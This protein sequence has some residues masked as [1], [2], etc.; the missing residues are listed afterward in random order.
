MGRPTQSQIEAKW[1]EYREVC[2]A[3]KI[4]MVPTERT[5]LT[6]VDHT[7]HCGTVW[8]VSISKLCAKPRCNK[9]A[10]KIVGEHNSR[11]KSG[12]PTLDK[13]AEKLFL[14]KLKAAG[15]NRVLVGNFLGSYVISKFKCTV[16]GTVSSTTG[17][18][19][20]K[21]GCRE[22]SGHATKTTQQHADE[23]AKAGIIPTGYI[24]AREQCWYECMA[25]RFQWESMPTNVLKKPRCPSCSPFNVY[26]VHT[27]VHGKSHFKLRSK[28]EL[29]V[30]K[31]LIKQFG[32]KAV[33]T[34]LT[35]GTPSIDLLKGKKHRPDFYIERDNLLVEVKGL[36]T[37]G[38]KYTSGVFGS[39]MFKLLKEKE[40]CAREQGFQYEVVIVDGWRNAYLELPDNWQYYTTASLRKHAK[41][42]SHYHPL[43]SLVL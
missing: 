34:D 11:L 38:L 17:S 14:A 39:G 20:I 6:K 19:A 22:C 29:E 4:K 35:H 31:I 13:G 18:N 41:E 9:C 30:L 21:Y 16:C 10:C 8:K 24:G 37:A 23:I 40:R 36:V 43:S 12:V 32:V 28:G 5:L 26:G 1:R 33:K 42:P 27:H 15:T 7:C 25:C 3:N 2:K